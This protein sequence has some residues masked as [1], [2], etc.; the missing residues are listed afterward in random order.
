METE[1][2][3]FEVVLGLAILATVIVLPFWRIFPKAGFS[4]WWSLAMVVPI[5]NFVLLFSLAF[6]EWPV[7]RELT[8][9]RQNRAS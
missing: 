2:S 3:P 8:Q 7:H 9:L 1:V 5:L 6:R 4:R